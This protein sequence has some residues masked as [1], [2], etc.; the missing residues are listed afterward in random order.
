FAASRLS[1]R[2]IELSPAVAGSEYG[3]PSAHT[4]TNINLLHCELASRM[5]NFKIQNSKSNFSTAFG[6]VKSGLKP[7]VKNRAMH[8]G[9][10]CAARMV[11]TKADALGIGGQTPICRGTDEPLGGK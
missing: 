4:P 2:A 8:G 10:E 11:K 1:R 3:S 9:E 5:F 7:A 6:R